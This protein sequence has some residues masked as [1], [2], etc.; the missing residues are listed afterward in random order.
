MPAIA[1][2]ECL[3]QVR[4]CICT[5]TPTIRSHVAV[6][7]VRPEGGGGGGGK[8]WEDG[9]DE[10]ADKVTLLPKKKAIYIHI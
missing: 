6:H 9:L 5:L 1:R 2:L 4:I 3:L 7:N 8:A 10:L